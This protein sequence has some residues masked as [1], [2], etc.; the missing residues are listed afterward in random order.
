MLIKNV[1]WASVERSQCNRFEFLMIRRQSATVCPIASRTPFYLPFG[2]DPKSK[3]KT[4]TY[5]Y[6]KWRS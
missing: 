4:Q 5:A 1:L 6:A 2:S 3:L